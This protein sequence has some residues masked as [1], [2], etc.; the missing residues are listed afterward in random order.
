MMSY[1]NG[2]FLKDGG[3][4]DADK[5]E[6]ISDFHWW[7][8]VSYII[9]VDNIMMMMNHGQMGHYHH[10]FHDLLNLPP[11][12]KQGSCSDPTERTAW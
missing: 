3:I 12:V 5:R 7:W 6:D 4:Y 9:F 10:D 8:W 11:D 2:E 1:D